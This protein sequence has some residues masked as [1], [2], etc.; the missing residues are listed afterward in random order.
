MYLDVDKP[1]NGRLIDEATWVAIPVG[2]EHYLLAWY[3]K[4]HPAVDRAIAEYGL[5]R[6]RM[7]RR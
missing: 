4:P 3:L 1:V 6:V 2:A 7:V 5:S